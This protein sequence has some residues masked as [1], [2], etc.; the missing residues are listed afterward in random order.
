MINERFARFS[1]SVFLPM[2]R[3]QPR[4]SSFPPEVKTF[5]EYTSEIDNFMS[6]TTVRIEELR[7]SMLMVFDPSFISKL[8]DSYYGGTLTKT[9]NAK[10][11]FT[12]TEDRLIEILTRGLNE[13]L[14]NS[15][16]DLI[17]VTFKEQARE[18]THNLLLLLTAPIQSLFVVLS[19]NFLIL[20]RQHSRLFIRS[21]HSSLLHRNCGRVSSQR[22]LMMMLHGAIGWNVP[23]WIFRFLWMFYWLSQRLL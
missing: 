13:V 21:R 15:W 1:R 9:V 20:T 22:L 10:A 18:V 12:A 16:R 3:I 19:Y 7:G 14:E 11:E 6:L 5:D 17:P 23:F 8:T 4:V 2:L